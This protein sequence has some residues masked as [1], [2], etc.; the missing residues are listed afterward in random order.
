MEHADEVRNIESDMR[1]AG[2]A[3]HKGLDRELRSWNQLAAEVN[4]YEATVDDY[5]NDLCSRDYLA[6]FASRASKDLRVQVQVHIAGAD[7]TFRA[8]TIDDAEGLLG[9]YYRIE[10]KDGWWWRRK[11][12]SGP[13]AEWLSRW[14]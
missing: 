5:T 11:P 6:D 12:S 13:L 1:A 4:T 10:L 8:A 7:A 9:K 3:G 2:W 14:A